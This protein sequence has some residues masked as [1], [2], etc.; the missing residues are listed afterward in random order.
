MTRRFLTTA[1]AAAAAGVKPATIRSWQN[2]G[3]LTPYGTARRRRYD[4][5]ELS[6]VQRKMLSSRIAREP[7]TAGFARHA[8]LI[9][10]YRNTQRSQS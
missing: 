1:Q 6:E 5:F 3:L 10:G 7:L 8:R 2:R 4:A 9:A